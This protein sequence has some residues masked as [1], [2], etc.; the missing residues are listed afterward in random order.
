VSSPDRTPAR[1]LDAPTL[2][3]VTGGRKL[4]H[5][6]QNKRWRKKNPAKRL[7]GKTRYYAQTQGAPNTGKHWTMTE[8]ERITATDRP[9]D[10]ELYTEL[11]RS[12]K[13]IQIKRVRSKGRRIGPE[14]LP[15][16]DHMDGPAA[17]ASIPVGEVYPSVSRPPLCDDALCAHQEPK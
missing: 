12:V 4:T 2:K 10:R 6:E 7:A 17:V 15:L 5:Y 8:V 3:P 9:T 14:T 16:L 13:A 11:G 1:I